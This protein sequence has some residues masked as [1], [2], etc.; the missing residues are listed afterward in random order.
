M[1]KSYKEII[2]QYKD[3][4]G[5]LDV[6]IGIQTLDGYVSE[7]AIEEVA[8]AYDMPASKVYE[9]ASFY[10]MIRLNPQAKIQVEICR[11]APCHV[12]G[13]KA[14]I[15]TVENY[16]NIKVGEISKNGQCSFHY[17]ECLGQCQDAPSMLINGKLY[18]HLTVESVKKILSKEGCL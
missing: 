10:S 12:A 15:E 4:G 6:L 5:I 7:E 16:L 1:K 9:T 18:S 2:D 8:T 17:V 3:I 11:S 14:I 13:A